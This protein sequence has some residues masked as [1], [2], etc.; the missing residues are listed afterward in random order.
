[1]EACLSSL[2]SQCIKKSDPK[3]DAIF[4]T[5]FREELSCVSVVKPSPHLALAC[6]CCWHAHVCK[7]LLMTAPG[8]LENCVFFANEQ[9]EMYLSWVPSVPLRGS[10]T[11]YSKHREI[12]LW[13]WLLGPELV[14]CGRLPC[15]FTHRF[16][17]AETQKLVVSNELGVVRPSLFLL[18]S[19]HTGLDFVPRQGR[20]R[21][22]CLLEG[23]ELATSV[24]PLRHRANTWLIVTE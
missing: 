14:T 9:G 23:G 22:Q 12:L 10:Q 8:W 21:T 7:W 5:Y 19:W 17:V 1:M 15:R 13:S 18:K 16:S 4:S 2:S 6:Q 24:L 11:R 3:P 20:K